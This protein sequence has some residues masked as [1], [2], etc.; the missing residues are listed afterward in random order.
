MKW[1]DKIVDDAVVKRLNEQSSIIDGF[2]SRLREFNARLENLENLL[3]T[4]KLETSDSLKKLNEDIHI[5]REKFELESRRV[6]MRIDEKDKLLRENMESC[7]TGLIV[8]LDRKL[9]S[10]GD[11][12]GI[13]T[14]LLKRIAYLEGQVEGQVSDAVK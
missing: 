13:V 8:R 7:F 5:Q 4:E 10:L 6:N 2:E 11:K 14:D 1:M 9:E 12:K 3:S